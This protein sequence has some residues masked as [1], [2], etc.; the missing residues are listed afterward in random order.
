MTPRVAV[1]GLGVMGR[2]HLRLLS[3]MEDVALVGA[4]DA[5]PEARASAEE[6]ADVPVVAEWQ[7]VLELDP[8]A[9][10]NAL[11][12]GMH[13]EVTEALLRTGKHVLVEKPIAAT[14][15]QAAE[16][17]R[18]AE[19]AGVILMVGN[20]ERFNPAVQAMKDLVNAGRLGEV[21]HASA[22]RVGVARPAIPHANVALDLAIHDLDVLA[23]VLGEDGRLLFAAGSAI[24]PNQ[25][26]DHMDIV[27][28][29]GATTAFVQANWITPIKIRRLAITGTRGYAEADYIDQSVRLYQSAP[30]MI[31]GMPWD[32]FAVSTESRAVTV[33][34]T[35]R[36]PLREEL[37]HF[38]A[39]LRAGSTPITDARTA[40]KALAL[41]IEATQAARGVGLRA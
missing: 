33:P 11:P 37:A 13:Y 10:V 35:R 6:H 3:T 15:E 4:C 12:T 31:R 19:E 18:A 36:E 38:L 9:V 22:R 2:Q 32:F 40:T 1:L 25:L 29:Y 20:V 21:V 7:G 27:V 14:V 30:E 5:S 28:R 41:A 23:Y 8:D 17:A 24:G 16:L 26:E 39:C 34:V